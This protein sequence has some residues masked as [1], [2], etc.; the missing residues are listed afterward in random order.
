MVVSLSSFLISLLSELV[1]GQTSTFKDRIIT[2]AT[3]PA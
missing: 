1:I 3:E 2:F